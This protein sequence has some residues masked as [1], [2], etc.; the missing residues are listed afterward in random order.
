[1]QHEKRFKVWKACAS[2]QG[3]HAMHYVRFRP[4]FA[5]APGTLAATNGR[6]LAVVPVNDE[7]TEPPAL[8]DPKALEDSAKGK[9]EFTVG[10]RTSEYC[11]KSGATVRV[12][13]AP[14]GSEFPKIEAVI[15]GGAPK[16]RICLNPHLLLKLAEAIGVDGKSELGLILEWTS[17]EP[18]APIC[19][20]PAYAYANEG[21]TAPFGVLMPITID[22]VK[23]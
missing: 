20:R 1:M 4:A 11:A 9:C 23:L 8:I 21:A 18:T 7:G 13:N 10:D 14:D 12:D 22:G 17:D 15:P 3:R 16:R 2:E 5:G 6:I 19:V